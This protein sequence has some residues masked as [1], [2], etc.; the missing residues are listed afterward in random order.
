[1]DNIN[2]IV[3]DEINSD[4]IGIKP[5]IFYSIFFIQ[6]KKRLQIAE[7]CN[8]NCMQQLNKRKETVLEQ[9]LRKLS[10]TNRQFT[11][12]FYLYSS[13]SNSTCVVRILTK[14]F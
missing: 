3:N 1:M 2:F 12:Y 7:A 14:Y 6:K 13:Y 10:G 11:V 4:F 9:E 5:E 8:I